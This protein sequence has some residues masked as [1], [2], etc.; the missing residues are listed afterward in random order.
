MEFALSGQKLPAGQVVQAMLLVTVQNDETYWP[1]A[2]VPH[3][4]HDAAFAVVEYEVPATQDVHT[5]SAVMVQ[6]LLR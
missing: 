6:R 5:A 1:M 4:V 3:V 2:Q